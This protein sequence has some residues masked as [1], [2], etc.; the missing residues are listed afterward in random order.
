MAREAGGGMHGRRLWG[1]ALLLTGLLAGCGGLGAGSPPPANPAP[2]GM[3]A[4]RRASAPRLRVLAFYDETSN[5]AP[6][7]PL[8]LLR[9]HPGLVTDLAPFWYE[10]EPSGN[11]LSKPQGAIAQLARRQ[12]LR[13]VPLFNNAGGTDVFLHAATTR[14]VA[15]GDIAHLVRTR[16][17][18]GVNI[19]FQG[20]KPADQS[21][22]TA[23]MGELRHRLPKGAFLSMSVV[24]LS[25]LNGAAS[26]YNYAALDKVTDAM[27]L[28]A[29]DLHGDGTAPG[30]VSPL[31]W[32]KRAVRAALAAGIQPAKLYL[33][34]A[35][36][37]YD[38]TVGSTTAVTV[39]LKVMHQRHYGPYQWQPGPAEARLTYT[40][41]GS[42]HVIWFVPDRGAVARIRVAQAFH[43]G[44]VAFWRIGYEDSRW[45]SAV[46]QAV[47]GPPAAA[48]VRRQPPRPHRSPQHKGRA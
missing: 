26:A 13:L 42:R 21:D 47:T 25:N 37:G 6:P 35:D 3:G 8:A 41:A 4:A 38:W 11:I 28:M 46:A 24:P 7:H 17:Y 33:G 22:L 45:W 19:D 44:G 32:V 29:Y 40:R 36:Y 30:P 48:A 2:L 20:L 12:H 15:V 43:L 34:I 9:A 5:T 27:V 18:A 14:T 10:V 23:F 31:P 1:V 16:H 39:P